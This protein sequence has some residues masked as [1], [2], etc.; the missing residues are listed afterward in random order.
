[1]LHTYGAIPEC[2]LYILRNQ[3]CTRIFRY[4][5]K[6]P[7]VTRG[8]MQFRTLQPREEVIGVIPPPPGVT[9]NFVR[10]AY[11]GHSYLVCHIVFSVL[12]ATLVA[13]RLYTTR[14]VTHRVGLDDYSVAFS[15]LLAFSS[16]ITFCLMLRY[17]LGH[18][19]WD[20]RFSTFNRHFMK[21]G[22]IAGTFYGI[23]IMFAKISIL[24]FYLRF[25]QSKSIRRIIYATMVFVIIYSILFSFEWMYACR[26]IDKYWDLTITSGSCIDWLKITIVSG[27]FNTATD[28]IILLLPVW[29][30]WNLRL[31]KRQKIGVM[32]VMMTGGL[33]VAVS[34]IRTKATVE[35]A[36][37]LDLTWSMTNPV[38]W[39]A[40]EMHVAII[41]ACLPEG[42]PFLRRHFPKVIGSSLNSHEG[43]RSYRRGSIRLKEFSVKHADEIPLHQPPKGAT[44]GASQTDGS[45]CTIEQA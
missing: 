5:Q 6:F 12:S 7:L 27:A 8:L 14:F 45:T 28:A 15:W 10:P 3:I 11:N 20:V 33:V 39:G 1:M 43:T 34:I 24:I 2:F 41:C 31:P 38:I 18:H 42:K 9:P 4:F 21:I 35:L 40:I 32:L 44:D 30:L 16:S 37:T 22:A 13:L 25:S 23:S 36:K 26:P 29:M 19:I 17:G